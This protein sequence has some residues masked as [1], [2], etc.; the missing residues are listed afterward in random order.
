MTE[1]TDL[2][3]DEIEGI[4]GSLAYNNLVEALN[5]VFGGRWAERWIRPDGN[6]HDFQMIIDIDGEA[7]AAYI[8]VGRTYMSG[9]WAAGPG[10]RISVGVPVSYVPNSGSF[11]PDGRYRDWVEDMIGTDDEKDRYEW[12]ADGEDVD[13][14]VGLLRILERYLVQRGTLKGRLRSLRRR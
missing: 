12:G 11:G 7:G 3:D 4:R 5:R 10:G 13:K 1:S 9:M 14:I 6:P 2:L 8:C